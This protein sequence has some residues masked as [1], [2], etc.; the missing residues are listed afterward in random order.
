MHHISTIVHRA[1]RKE[2]GYMFKI[3]GQWKMARPPVGSFL[4]RLKDA[5]LV[6]TGAADAVVWDDA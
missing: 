4:E 2:A 6:L 1:K 3:D 5:W